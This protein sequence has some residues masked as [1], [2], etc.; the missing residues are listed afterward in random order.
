MS[1]LP[2]IQKLKHRKT[3][4]PKYFSEKE[5]GTLYVDV[6]NTLLDSNDKVNEAVTEMIW[7]AKFKGWTIVVWSAQGEERAHFAKRKAKIQS[8]CHA[9]G[10]PTATID[11]KSWDD[12]GRFTD[13]F[14]P[15]EP[16]EDDR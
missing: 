9:L 10:K 13:H 15:P 12:W 6:D 3:P 7:K 2:I 5:P 14:T 1:A 11:D 8:I 4:P 16:K